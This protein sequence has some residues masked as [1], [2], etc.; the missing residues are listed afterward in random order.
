MTPTKDWYEDDAFWTDFYDI[1]F[2]PARFTQARE[3]LAESPLLRFAPG[4]RVLDLCCG[5]GVFTAPLARLG[6]R[7]T[8]VDRSAV[9]LERAARAC[10]EAGTK[11]RLVEA[12][13]LEYAEPDSFDVALSLFTSF[14]YFPEPADNLRVLRTLHDSLV[15][16][17]QLVLDVAGKEIL[18]RKVLTPKVIERGE[19]E[20]LVQTDTALDAWTRLRSDWVL[21]RG[22][23]VRRERL[24]WFVYSAAELRAMAVQAGFDAVEVFGGFDGRPYDEHADRLLLRAVRER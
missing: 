3:L 12:D 7:V 21:V 13:V 6:H 8:G 11:A 19:D 14:G 2:S 5:A 15:P 22:D 1:L 20:L 9:L 24:E 4:S 17:G 18:A 10:A 23:R 16:G